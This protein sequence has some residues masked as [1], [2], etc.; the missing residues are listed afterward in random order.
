MTIG[1]HAREL[2]G[3][4]RMSWVWKYVSAPG[5]TNAVDNAAQVGVVVVVAV[6]VAC[7]WD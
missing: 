7:G 6:V 3:R 2:G 1:S 4:P 5:D